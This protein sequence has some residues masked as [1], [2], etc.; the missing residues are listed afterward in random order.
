MKIYNIMALLALVMAYVE[1]KG[2][3]EG[4]LLKKVSTRFFG[5]STKNLKSRSNVQNVAE[6]PSSKVHL[7]DVCEKPP[8]AQ[9]ILTQIFLNS[10][11]STAQGVFRLSA[12]KTEVDEI[13]RELEQDGQ[14]SDATT[15]KLMDDPPLAAAMLKA[16]FKELEL[17]LFTSEAIET[18][19]GLIAPEGGSPKAEDR[20]QTINELKTILNEQGCAATVLGHYIA[21]LYIVSKESDVTLM[22]ASNLGLMLGPNLATLKGSSLLEIQ[23]LTPMLNHIAIF[24]I[25]NADRLFPKAVAAVEAMQ[26]TK[27]KI[28]HHA[29]DPAD[30]AYFMSSNTQPAELQVQLQNLVGNHM[31]DMSGKGGTET[32][33][34]LEEV[35][36]Y[37][38]G[39]MKELRDSSEIKTALDDLAKGPHVAVVGL[40]VLKTWIAHFNQALLPFDRL[41]K[42][43]AAIPECS[44]NGGSGG[45]SAGSNSHSEDL[46]NLLRSL[47][48]YVYTTLGK[49]LE[50]FHMIDTLHIMTKLDAQGIANGWMET[51][52]KHT[53]G[54]EE[55]RRQMTRIIVHLIKHYSTI[56]ST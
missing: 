20:E 35:A 27:D 34:S 12:R 17:E 22:K 40:E 7:P 14:L 52:F 26:T 28:Q 9:L 37:H 36:N 31:H 4:S 8:S 41:G 51:L 3:G 6:I 46:S 30:L 25:E 49:L 45:G 32:M 18:L 39:K 16:W 23:K 55:E 5:R 44:G 47:D 2:K 54:S 53:G 24:M 48:P 19:G 42:Y 15:R 13:Q 21:L 38:Y 50:L 11:W 10:N 56:F 29:T 43:C 1:T 33:G